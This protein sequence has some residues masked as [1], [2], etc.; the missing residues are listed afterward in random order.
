MVKK[1]MIGHKH[2]HKPKEKVKKTR[3]PRQER[4]IK[5]K[6]LIVEAA[7]KLF[8]EKGYHN[9]NTKEITQ[10]AGVAT[11][12]FYH[13]FKD[14]KEVFKESLIR[15]RALFGQAI[16]SYLD[17][18]SIDGKNFR[19]LLSGLFKCLV[20]A[21]QIYAGL[22]NELLALRLED[23][24]INQILANQEKESLQRTYQYI[25]HIKDYLAVED[26]ETASVI[27]F[28]IMDRMVDVITYKESN[29]SDDRLIHESVEM[30]IKYLGHSR[31]CS[32]PENRQ[33]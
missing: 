24:E 19:E 12:C 21:H 9:T 25:L 31:E 3:E 28:H 1:M 27:V 11:G 30:I 5:T 32:K 18:V 6:N 20:D 15:Y 2:C 14:K 23:A 8:S 10:E 29:L 16:E 4:S 26:I 7:M 17:S 22:H 13:Y 33:I